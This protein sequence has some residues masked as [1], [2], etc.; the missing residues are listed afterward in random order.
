LP[1]EEEAAA[2]DAWIEE[3]RTR[4]NAWMEEQRTL[5][6]SEERA[7]RRFL[8]AL[9]GRPAEPRQQGQPPTPRLE[10]LVSALAEHGGESGAD[11]LWSEY[12]DDGLRTVFRACLEALSPA[13]MQ[14]FLEQILSRFPD[15]PSVRGPGLQSL[16]HLAV[17]SGAPLEILRL[18]VSKNPGA[19]HFPNEFDQL[20]VHN[21]FYRRGSP[22]GA[23]IRALVDPDRA[24]LE[25][26]DWNGSLPL[27]LACLNLLQMGGPQDCEAIRWLIEACP[28]A[29]EARDDDGRTPIMVALTTVH[30]ATDRNGRPLPT[31][32]ET[33]ALEL[34]LEMVERAPE[35][36]YAAPCHPLVS[37]A[38]ARAAA[39][40]VVCGNC[41]H[42]RELVSRLLAAAGPDALQRRNLAGDLPL[43]RACS[44]LLWPGFRPE[45]Q[46]A[47]ADVVRML[48]DEYPQ[49]LGA[50]KYG[51]MTPILAALSSAYPDGSAA[52][53]PE[54]VELLRRMIQL[55]GPTSLSGTRQTAAAA[56]FEPQA[57]GDMPEGDGDDEG[58]QLVVAT[59]L[60]LACARCP[61]PDLVLALV[62]SRPFALCDSLL[63][64]DST[65]LLPGTIVKLVTTEA[66]YVFLAL[67]EA[68]LH[69]T[70]RGAVPDAIRERVRQAVR[71]RVGQNELKGSALAA[72]QAVDRQVRGIAFWQ[73][74]SD[75]LNGGSLQEFLRGH[76]A[77]QELVCG[78]Y[79]MNKAGRLLRGSEPEEGMPAESALSDR[80]HARILNAARGEPD[81]LFWH[82]RDSPSLFLR[83]NPS[84]S[85]RAVR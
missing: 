35:S 76:D 55:G 49:A 37:E 26:R 81:C 24:V 66:R 58:G 34:L 50:R 27:H 77:F 6:R 67:A 17:D 56:G 68:L 45:Q 62:E 52:P 40:H 16:L 47:V 1:L 18:L 28:A 42:S 63:T 20:P 14:D 12:M 71:E 79:R 23:E 73:L 15:L 65:A 8:D 22:D 59:A 84:D 41:P 9:R 54:A 21:A 39:L 2:T 74:R 57:D 29:L 19:L 64:G 32:F 33:G 48:V 82:L 36:V 51:G 61:D 60:E 75:V 11:L 4:Q 53:S 3:Q 72:V 83:E 70:T 10:A 69:D 78:V 80:D 85:S 31:T 25:R 38:D 43:H 30:F 44:R 7:V 5:Q 46:R 13:E